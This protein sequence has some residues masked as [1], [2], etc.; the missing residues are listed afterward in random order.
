MSGRSVAAIVFAAL[1]AFPG[2]LVRAGGETAPDRVAGL[3]TGPV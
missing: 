1:A 2:A 3:N